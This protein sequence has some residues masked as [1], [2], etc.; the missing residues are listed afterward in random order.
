M[1]AKEDVCQAKRSFDG[2]FA[3]P[4]VSMIGSESSKW[5]LRTCSSV[6][7]AKRL[8]LLKG[9]VLYGKVHALQP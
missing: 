3:S 6:L 9:I 5:W 7:L 1:L 2:T 8:E 4:V